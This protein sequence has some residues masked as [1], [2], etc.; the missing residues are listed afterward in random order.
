MFGHYGNDL[1]L[2]YFLELHGQFPSA[3]THTAQPTFPLPPLFV[4]SLAI[5][6]N[7]H[8]SV[9]GL[10]SEIGYSSSGCS[11]YMGSPSSI[12]SYGTYSPT[13][14][15]R[16]ISSHSLQKNLESSPTGY[17]ES[18]T[19]S[20]RKVLSIGDLQQGVNL[21]QHSQR[22]NGPLASERS[23]IES[24]NRATR[25]SPEEKRERIDRY[26]SKRNLRNFN[27]KIKYEC[28]KT[29]ADTRPRVR[30]R[31]AKNDEIEKAPQSQWDH[32]YVEEDDEDDDS[33]I[34]ILDALSTNLMP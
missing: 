23:I 1:S 21:A 24:M 29:L 28:R 34:R 8:D 2:D 30:G 11:S 4:P 18:E 9:S 26:R 33:W 14:I 7:E 5:P 27:K 32:A 25:Y 10:R 15:Q 13:L 31:F 6:S 17:F 22:S 19:S 12:T 20:V 3:D 16:S